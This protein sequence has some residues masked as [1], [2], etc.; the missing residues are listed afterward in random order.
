M[1]PLSEYLKIIVFIIIIV[2][3]L[4]PII[5]SAKKRYTDWLEVKTH[6]GVVT[7]NDD[8][9][10]DTNNYA[11]DLKKFFKDPSIKAI[12]LKI[13]SPGGAPAA[14]QELF[15]EI[16]ELKK[17]YGKPVIVYAEN[18]C[19]SGSYY[20]ACAAD[21]IIT[22][23]A[24]FVGAIG[25]YM[26]FPN[27]HEFL[28]SYKIKYTAIQTGTYKSPSLY[29]QELTSDQKKMFQ[30]LTDDTYAQFVSD[31][32]LRR[33]QLAKRDKAQW[34]DGKTFTGRQALELGLID[35]LGS[36]STLVRALKAKAPIEGE[37]VWVHP[38]QPG[39]FASL[40]STKDDSEYDGQNVKGF[41]KNA[42][43]A[44]FAT[45]CKPTC[46]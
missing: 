14:C 33:P 20:I 31:V 35:E 26:A 23:P 22:Q 41:S 46:S 37:I 9:I 27:F 18:F 13:D 28:E 12:V 32:M 19:A 17:E 45:I 25:V 4:P 30:S 21:H 43:K 36:Q 16:N 29:L 5:T 38:P 8:L 34:A 11:K 2:Q 7:I 6:V 1:P 39:L 42:L 24:T 15:L 3:F 10:E 44:L 40:F